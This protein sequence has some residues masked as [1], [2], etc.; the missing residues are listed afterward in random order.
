MTLE[1][2]Q[3]LVSVIIPN[4]NHARYLEQRLDS[5][6]GQTYPN[7]EVI[8]LDDCSTDNSL[9]VINRYKD[10]PHLSQIV[11]NETN[12]GS[13]FKQWNKGFSL[14]KGELIWI[15]ESDDFCDLTL[16]EEL[17]SA[18]ISRKNIVL[19]FTSYIFY[20]EESGRIVKPR[21]G[22]IASYSG[23]HYIKTRMARECFIHNA[24][25]VV[26]RK[27]ALK[28]M[29]QDYMSFKQC[30]DYMFWTNMCEQGNLVIVNHNLSTYRLHDSSV[31]SQNEQSGVS[32]LEDKR[33]FDYINSKY[34]LTLFQKQLVYAAKYRIYTQYLH[35]S[36]NNKRMEI[37]RVWNIQKRNMKVDKFLE[38]LVGSVER[39]TGLLI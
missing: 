6:F 32:A 38:W 3:P 7:F 29:P 24:S 18:I 27:D 4:Y 35:F 8:I 25:G 30:G 11:V 26:F 12:S 37:L 34:W 39:H 21:M 10:N 36:S 23:L 9:E 13:V 17:V 31:T 2:K 15:A 19:A 5:V 20:Y 22:G 28:K 16:L 1:Q 14:S 33:V